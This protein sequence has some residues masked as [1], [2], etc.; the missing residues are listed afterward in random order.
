P[1]AARPAARRLV[2]LAADGSGAFPFGAGAQA[3]RDFREP[4][5]QRARDGA[6]RGVALHLFA[7]GGVAEQPPPFVDAL[8]ANPASSFTRVQARDPADFFARRV[9]LP[10]LAAVSI[11][12]AASGEATGAIEFASDG[13]F[14]ASVPLEPGENRLL[15]RAATSDGS[16]REAPLVLHFDPSAYRERLLAAEAAR[17]R[18]V[19]RKQVTLEVVD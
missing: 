1:G 7:L 10:F 11:H 15:V 3:D 13:R 4:N 14:A 9:S 17:I 8:L 18:R 16:R 5:E 19:Q 12:D 2:L 6:A